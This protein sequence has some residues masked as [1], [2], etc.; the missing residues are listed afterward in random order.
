MTEELLITF[1]SSLFLLGGASSEYNMIHIGVMMFFQGKF[2]SFSALLK[3]YLPFTI[4]V[5][6]IVLAANGLFSSK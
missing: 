6:I 3:T 4:I 2:V 5:L 1:L